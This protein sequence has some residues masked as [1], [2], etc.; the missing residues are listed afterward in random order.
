M[1]SEVAPDISNLHELALEILELHALAPYSGAERHHR[2]FEP[3]RYF[4]QMR[5]IVRMCKNMEP[6]AFE[7]PAQEREE[8]EIEDGGEMEDPKI[9]QKLCDQ[10][11]DLEFYMETLLSNGENLSRSR[12]RHSKKRQAE[13]FQ[14]REREAPEFSRLVKNGKTREQAEEIVHRTRPEYWHRQQRHFQERPQ[15]EIKYGGTR[16]ARCNLPIPSISKQ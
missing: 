13:M 7:R 1:F 11:L 15:R 10:W 16:C 5:E 14:W 3:D 4:E 9:F 8:G 12:S 2:W 6:L